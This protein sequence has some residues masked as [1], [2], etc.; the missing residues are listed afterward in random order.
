MASKETYQCQ[1]CGYSSP[2]R[3]EFMRSLASRE[4]K[5]PK[6]ADTKIK[7]KEVETGDVFG[8]NEDGHYEG[9]F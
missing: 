7:A 9:D 4:L 8:Y 1:Y 2:N 3:Y 6:C 5:C